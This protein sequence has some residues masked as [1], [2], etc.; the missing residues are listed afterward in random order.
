MNVHRIFAKRSLKKRLIQLSSVFFNSVGR[1]RVMRM[2]NIVMCI[3]SSASTSVYNKL[4]N[5]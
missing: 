5:H 1:H 3:I 2:I 4:G